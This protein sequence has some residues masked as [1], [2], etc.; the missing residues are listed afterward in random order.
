MIKK[1]FVP[2]VLLSSI[3]IWTAVASWLILKVI[4]SFTP[5]RVSEEEEYEGLDVVEHEERSYDLI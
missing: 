4:G 5:L 3:G 2:I 1:L